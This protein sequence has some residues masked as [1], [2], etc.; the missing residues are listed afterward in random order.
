MK[1]PL[2]A[3]GLATGLISLSAFAEHATT[4][5]TQAIFVGQPLQLVD[6]QGQCTLVR[7]DQSRMKLDMEW[8]C[9]FS[10]NNQQKLRIETFDNIPIFSVWRSEHMPAPSHHCLSKMQAVRQIKGILEAGVVSTFASCGP[11]TDQKMYITPFVW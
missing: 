7:P 6:D 5:T 11:G 3:I 9:S 10:L 1:K 8:P 2:L 4:P